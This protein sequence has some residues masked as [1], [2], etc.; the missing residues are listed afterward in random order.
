MQ[1]YMFIMK[2]KELIVAKRNKTLIQHYKY[3]NYIFS[4]LNTI[5]DERDND[6]NCFA[7]INLMFC[8]FVHLR[9]ALPVADGVYPKS[10]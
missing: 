3:I 7:Y 5:I 6:D 10:A 9:I 8:N 4:D 2:K 1:T